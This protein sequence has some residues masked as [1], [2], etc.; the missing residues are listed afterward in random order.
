MRI[1]QVAPLWEPVPPTGYG[2]IELVVGLLTDE[3]VRRGHQVTLFASG[4]SHTLARL[5]AVVPQAV[6]LN[7]AISAAAAEKIQ[8]DRVRS[9]ASQFDL[10]HFH[11]WVPPF[12]LTES[13]GIP[14]L[15]TLHGPLTPEFSELC[16]RYRHHNFISISDAQRP[17]NLD[18]NYIRTI[19]NGIDPERY[20]FKAA[21]E[22][23][24]SHCEGA[25]AD[26]PGGTIASDRPYLAFLG[27]LSP[28]KGPHHAI[29]I[30]QR[31][32]LPLKLAGKVDEIDRAF[33]EQAVLPHLD[34]HAIEYLGEVD[35]ASKITLLS[36][37]VATLFPITWE[38]P[39]GLIMIESMATGT[40]V[41]AMN[42]GSVPEVI[43][44]GKTGFICNS[45]DQMAEA[46][47]KVDSLNRR[48]CRELVMRH[49]SAGRMVDK[50]EAAYRKVLDKQRLLPTYAPIPAVSL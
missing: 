1:A 6:R 18:L 41:I 10:V 4:D 32:G 15:Y 35:H 49:F 48:N 38:E 11:N 14:T 28:E 23:R 29:A 16:S 45:F 3:L 17:A 37:A 20:P 33:F 22:N 27:R 39:F 8:L 42:R 31:T 12:E 50:Y 44:S 26:M 2:G 19:H 47:L 46:V 30:A 25:A 40:P 24:E 34:G 13:L 43:V 7:P 5:E 9:L 21:A 36:D